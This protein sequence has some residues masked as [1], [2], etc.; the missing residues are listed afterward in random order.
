MRKGAIIECPK[1]AQ[2]TR[3]A[4]AALQIEGD[5][6]AAK[7]EATVSADDPAV[8]EHLGRCDDRYFANNEPIAD[9]LFAWIKKKVNVI[10][11]S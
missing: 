5:V 9:R 3:D 10:R 8:L 6:T 4:I 7:V 2:I 11:L 1:T